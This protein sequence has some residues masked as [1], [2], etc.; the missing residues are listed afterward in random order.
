MVFGPLLY[1]ILHT[2]DMFTSIHRAKYIQHHWPGVLDQPCNALYNITHI[3]KIYVISR[4]K[5][6]FVIRNKKTITLGEDTLNRIKR[7]GQ[8]GDTYNIV[9]NKTLDELWELRRKVKK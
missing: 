6:R 4:M 3:S 1:G 5:T 7:Y 8:M 2:P 9:F